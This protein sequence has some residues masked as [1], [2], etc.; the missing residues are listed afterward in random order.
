MN[1]YEEFVKWIRKV[2]EEQG[3][4]CNDSFI[5]AAWD[6]G[7]FDDMLDDSEAYFEDSYYD[8][9]DEVLEESDEVYYD[10]PEESGCFYS[11]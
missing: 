9:D 8:Y 7:I 2:A 5:K 1:M 4:D 10:N 6:L 11:G 3:M